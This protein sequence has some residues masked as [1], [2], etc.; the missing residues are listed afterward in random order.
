MRLKNVYEAADAL[1][2]FRLSKE[3]CERYGFHDN[4]GVIVD[5]GKEVRGVLC[6]LDL[7]RRAVEEAVKTGANVIFTHHPAIFYPVSSL[8]A[9]D[10]VLLA[11]QAGISVISAHLNLDAAPGGIDEELMF[12]LGGGAC[13]VMHTL[14]EGGY[15]RVYAVREEL[16]SDFAVRVKARFSTERMLVYGER[17]VKKVASFCGAGLDESAVAFACGRGADTVVSSDAKHHIIAA[18]VE[19]GVNVVLMTHYASEQ[20]GFVR[21]A[22]RL[23]EKIKGTP[24]RVFTDE[25]FL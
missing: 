4:S 3:Y 7:S 6:S 24:V 1:A 21:F 9:E 13:E 16:P 5:C 20:Y 18:L 10:P 11:A 12:G 14:S 8:R 19:R 25:R 17:P 22:E 15:G 2:P 23:K